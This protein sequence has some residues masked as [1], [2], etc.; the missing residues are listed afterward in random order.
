MVDSLWRPVVG[1]QALDVLRVL[2][3]VAVRLSRVQPKRAHRLQDH[4]PVEDFNQDD[5][6]CE[7]AEEA[8]LH[9]LEKGGAGRA[10]GTGT[11]EVVDEDVCV[12]ED[13]RPV[14]D[15]GEG[16]HGGSGVR[17]RG[18]ACVFALRGP[19]IRFW[20]LTCAWRLV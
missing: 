6:G 11:G 20:T 16:G 8:V 18:Q 12:N 17:F 13:C 1:A 19:C 14:G 7:P 9:S 5:G 10:E 2:F 15:L 3:Q 4:Q